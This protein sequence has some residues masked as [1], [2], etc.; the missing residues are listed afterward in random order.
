M[1]LSGFDN[2]NWG[3]TSRSSKG[4]KLATFVCL[5]MFFLMVVGIIIVNNI[6]KEQDS[7][8]PSFREALDSGHYDEALEIY[9]S[10]HDTVVAADPNDIDAISTQIEMMEEMESIVNNRLIEIEDKVR[11]ERYSLNQGDLYFLNQMGELTSSQISFWLNDLCEEFMLGTIQKPDVIFIFNEMIEIG[12]VSAFATP[13]LQEVEIIETAAGDVQ[14]AEKAYINLDYISAVQKYQYVSNNYEGFVYDFAISRIDEI[15]EVM[16]TPLI[17]QTEHMIETNKFYSAEMILADMAAIFPEDTRISHD[18]LEA[19]SHTTSTYEYRGEVTVLCVRQLIADTNLAG[20]D[21]G[22]NLTST[23]FYNMINE[24]YQNDYVLVDAETMAD[25]T[26]ATYMVERNLTVPEGKKPVILVIENLDYSAVNYLNGMCSRLLL[27]DRGE[28]CGEY[29]NSQGQTVVA[30]NAEAIG[31][32]DSFIESHPDF[33]FNG[34]KGVIS[35]C[36]HESVFGYVIS[37]DELDDKNDAL[38][39]IGRSGLNLNLADIQNNQAT[40]IE[41]MDTLKDTG[42]KF[43]T[44]TYNCINAFQADMD[45]IV[46]DTEKWFDQIGVLTGDIH[47]IVYPDGNYIYGTDE[48]AVYLKNNGIRIFFG[49]GSSPYHIYGDNYLYY[50]RIPVNPVTLQNYDFNEMFDVSRILEL[51]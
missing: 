40:V 12:N 4:H 5:F 30:R 20:H 32:L 49:Q 22:S 46:D 3:N 31:I 51:E 33:S 45:T 8:I 24:L 18:L 29:I 43:A 15:K 1:K 19:T 16:Y 42:W 50:D 39:S 41:I 17:E 36:G 28:V 23:Q 37:M 2:S 35:L 47:M 27:N 9:R 7:T 21:S 14:S 48:R 11:Y 26:N 38:E 13:L 6:I 10:V 44:S 25:M 34:A